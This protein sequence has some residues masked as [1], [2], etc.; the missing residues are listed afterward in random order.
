M[1]EQLQTLQ[2]E[3]KC[4]NPSLTENASVVIANKMDATAHTEE[5]MTQ[6]QHSTSLP[7][8]PISG[9]YRWN[10]QPLLDLLFKIYKD[11]T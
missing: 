6:L 4:Y 10:I 9:L 1:C 8:V 11:I 5:G 2:T 3:L 7:I